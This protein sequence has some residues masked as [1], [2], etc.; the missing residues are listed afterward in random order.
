LRGATTISANTDGPCDT[1]S[2]K[3]V[4][5]AECS[6]QKN[7]HC[8]RYLKHIATKT[9]NDRQLCLLFAHTYTVRP[10]LHSVDFLLTLLYKQFCNKCT[11]THTDGAWALVASSTVGESNRG[12]SSTALFIPVNGVPWKN[13]QLH[14]SIYSKLFVK[15]GQF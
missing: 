10:E 13:S 9:D 2:Q 5:H 3:I 12:P 15:S 4:L 1:A 7:T 8:K 6:N 14:M 11:T